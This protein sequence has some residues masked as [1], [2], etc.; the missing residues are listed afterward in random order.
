LVR[1]RVVGAFERKLADVTDI[2][3]A[4]P[5]IASYRAHFEKADSRKVFFG[6]FATSPLSKN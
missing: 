1:R 4:R 5:M 6:I 2:E 3:V